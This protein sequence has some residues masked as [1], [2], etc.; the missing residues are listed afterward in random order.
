MSMSRR[1]FL[2][3]AAA[4]GGT[5]ALGGLAGCSAGEEPEQG[6]DQ[7]QEP[8]QSQEEILITPAIDIHHHY[9]PPEV[10][11]AIEYDEA[12][13]DPFDNTI[14]TDLCTYPIMEQIHPGMGMQYGWFSA[15][16]TGQS[17]WV[18]TDQLRSPLN[19]YENVLD[20]WDYKLYRKLD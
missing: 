2:T 15:D 8:T 11:A 5:V 9:R 16:T 6:A 14:R 19:G 20:T 7:V 1:S 17:R 10:V 18:L 13:D 12:A 4:I 3:A